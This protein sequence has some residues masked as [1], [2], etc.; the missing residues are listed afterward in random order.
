MTNL[1]RTL[2]TLRP[3]AASVVVTI[4]ERRAVRLRAGENVVLVRR[5]AAAVD[6]VAFLG[7]GGLLVQVL[8]PC[9]SSRLRAMTTPLTF[10]QGPLP[11]RSRAFTACGPCELR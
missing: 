2:A 4:R 9:S 10:C 3:V 1:R 8:L 6:E 5:V 7:E 11:M